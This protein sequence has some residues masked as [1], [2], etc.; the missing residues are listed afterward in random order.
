M[1]TLKSYRRARK[2]GPSLL[3]AQKEAHKL[4]FYPLTFQAVRFM[5]KSGLLELL[6]RK[7]GIS[8]KEAASQTKLSAY[9]TGLMLDIAVFADIAE[10]QGDKY[11]STRLG[12]YLL[13]DEAVRVNIDFMHD[14]CY[15]GAFDLDK[16]LESGSPAGL[17]VFGDW[18]TIYQ[19][20][21]QLPQEVRKSWFAFDNFYSDLVFD[22]AA[23][24]VL[25]SSPGMVYDVGGN[26]A[27]FAMALLKADP[28]VKM[29]IIDLPP[30]LKL[31]IENLEKAGLHDR[32]SF[33]PIDVLQKDSKLPP[34][35]DAIWMSQFLDCFSPE[36]IVDILKKAAAALAENGKIFILEPF[37]DMQNDVAALSLSNISL[38]FTVMANGNSKMYRQSE[39]ESF[40]AEAGLS[41]F[42]AHQNLGEFDYTLLECFKN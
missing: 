40:L 12:R 9:A 38:Y 16:A 19:G 6:N 1:S 4:A 14:V 20:L 10:L 35:A 25:Q 33:F 28:K 17:K 36:Q 32:V 8:M 18:S 37:V 3:E 11:C 15:L 5:L 22:E 39:M 23:A 41:V 7:G 24:I 27:K 29:G 30:Q 42:K 26:T 21:G 13:E 34:L 31:S 2:N